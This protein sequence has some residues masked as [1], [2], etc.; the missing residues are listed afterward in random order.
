MDGIGNKNDAKDKAMIQ[1]GRFF[2]TRRNISIWVYNQSTTGF[3]VTTDILQKE[4][5]GLEQ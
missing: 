5:H 4:A 1:Y 2:L 3:N